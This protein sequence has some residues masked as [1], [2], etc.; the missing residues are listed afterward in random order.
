MQ[1]V[2]S[3]E[4]LLDYNRIKDLI[5]SSIQKVMEAQIPDLKDRVTLEMGEGPAA[6]GS[7]LLARQAKMAVAVEV[8]GAS[9]G[10]Q[11]D[12]SRGYI[13]RSKASALPFA[14]EIFAY[15]LARLATPFQG[16]MASSIRE[17]GRILLPGGQGV[18]IDYHP[19][20]LYS[21]RGTDRLRPAVSGVH[22]FEDYYRL[23]KTAGLR[24]VNVRE[25]FVDESMRKY[26]SEKEIQA[27]RN[28]K[29][30]PLI[31]FLFFYKPKLK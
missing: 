13:V 23:C 3:V 10:M 5:E 6:Y 28:L 11:G 26:F 25:I 8:G 14:D 17:I 24:V 19:F 12:I 30:T 2:M 31:A 22:R 29:G 20:G 4:S 27:Y 16:D 9:V 7:R 15:I 1:P 18:L 21:R